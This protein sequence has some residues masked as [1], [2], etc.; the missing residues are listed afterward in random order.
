M[1]R[2]CGLAV[3]VQIFWEVMGLERGPISLMSTTEDLLERKSSGSSLENLKYGLGDPL[4]SLHYTLYPQKF[5]LTSPTSRRR[6]VGIVRSRTKATE[7][8]T[9]IYVLLLYQLKIISDRVYNIKKR[10]WNPL[11][12][13]MLLRFHSK[14]YLP[15]VLYGLTTWTPANE[16]KLTQ[17]IWELCA[18]RNICNYGRSTAEWKHLQD[19]LHNAHSSRN[20]ILV[21]K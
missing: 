1:G 6:P 19:E 18:E 4:R 15:L 5:T 12:T 7:Y 14:L 9:C 2:L 17:P 3:R 8:L 10:I 16:R 13:K 20:I 21:I 11:N